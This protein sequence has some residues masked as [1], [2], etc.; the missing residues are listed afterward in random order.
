[1]GDKVDDELGAG[2]DGWMRKSSRPEAAGATACRG[3]G[4]AASASMSSSTLF[5]TS[6]TMTSISSSVTPTGSGDGVVLLPEGAAVAVVLGVND[7][8][9][10]EELI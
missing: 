6:S 1:L 10:G 9:D 7:G 4:D 5:G 3:R 2:A 8:A